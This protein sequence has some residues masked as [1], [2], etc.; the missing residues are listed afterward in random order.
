MKGVLS[1]GQQKIE[2]ITRKGEENQI[3]VQDR[4][5]GQKPKD[6]RKERAASY[7]MDGWKTTAHCKKKKQICL[8]AATHSEFFADDHV[9]SHD[10]MKITKLYQKNMQTIEPFCFNSLGEGRFFFLFLE[11][12]SLMSMNKSCLN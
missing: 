5:S 12:A 2:E 6:K 4:K 9:F 7:S 1:G 8:Q 3:V 11:L 10:A